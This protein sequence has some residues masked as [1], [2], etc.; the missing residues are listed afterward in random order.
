MTLDVVAVEAFTNGRLDRDDEETQRQ[1]DAALA[2]ARTYCGWHVSPSMADVELTLDGPGDRLLVLPTLKLTELSEVSEDGVELNLAELHWSARG[3]IAKRGGTYW[4]A[5][6]GSITVIFSHGYSSAP[7]FESVV[8]SAIDRGGFI[9]ESSP[10][11]IGRFRYTDALAP[12]GSAFTG[13]E[14]MVLD[15]YSLER[16]P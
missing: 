8:L 9:S 11:V 14:R 15:R 12:A 3:L 7:D 5:L 10:R 1:L 6:F 16:R 4:S 13:M 2:A